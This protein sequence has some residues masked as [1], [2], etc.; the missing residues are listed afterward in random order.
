MAIS[1]LPVKA[2]SP[3]EKDEAAGRELR[4]LE[5]ALNVALSGSDVD[6]LT[7]L[8]ADDF[9]STVTDGHVV[10]REN[11]LASPR[12]TKPDAAVKLSSNID[13]LDV[14]TY[15]N[16]ALVLV[17]SSWRVDGKQVGDPYQATHVWAKR[18]G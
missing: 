8:W 6:R 10:A 7:H 3:P 16:W 4:D 5:A 2:D 17:T 1:T 13:Y 18:R 9:L 15:G 11:R 12:A 14:H